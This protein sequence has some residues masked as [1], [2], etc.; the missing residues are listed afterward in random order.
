MGAAALLMHRQ[1]SNLCEVN[2]TLSVLC[3]PLCRAEDLGPPSCIISIKECTLA[4]SER[5]KQDL[6]LRERRTLGGTRLDARRSGLGNYVTFIKVGNDSRT[7][8][9][10]EAMTF[11]P[12]LGCVAICLRRVAPG[13]ILRLPQ[14]IP[15]LRLG[16]ECSMSPN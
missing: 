16:H 11:I 15:E 5:S 12:C 14:G 10:S 1:R 3:R 7:S 9:W 2:R 8:D 13:I 6:K 4:R